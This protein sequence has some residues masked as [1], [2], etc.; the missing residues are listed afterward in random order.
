MWTPANI[1]L[2]GGLLALVA[3]YIA[4]LITDKENKNEKDELRRRLDSAQAEI[5]R[6]T[7][8]LK[9][10]VT[11]GNGYC[12]VNILPEGGGKMGIYLTS[13]S[14]YPLYDIKVVVSPSVITGEPKTKSIKKNKE[15]TN[16][17]SPQNF[18]IDVLPAYNRDQQNN[19]VRLASAVF[20]NKEKWV[21]NIDFSARNGNWKQILEIYENENFTPVS[22][23]IIY[24]IRIEDKG[25]RQIVIK[26]SIDPNANNSILN[27]FERDLIP[28][29]N[30]N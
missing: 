11:G 18:N 20:Y 27:I 13:D 8:E 15:S 2:I 9:N 23:F 30:I 24:K 7:Q 12:Y 17:Y 25:Y 1:L 28:F 21:Y 29:E 14:N 5:L 22:S 19:M 26:E 4:T 6:L 10:D 16:H 3:T